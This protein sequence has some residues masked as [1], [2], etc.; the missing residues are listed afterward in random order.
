[1]ITLTESQ[2]KALA[3]L[4]G[5]P[6]LIAVVHYARLRDLGL[7]G[8]SNVHAGQRGRVCAELTEDGRAHL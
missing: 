8:K 7:V 6:A 2:K 5:G 3:S 4:A 1:M